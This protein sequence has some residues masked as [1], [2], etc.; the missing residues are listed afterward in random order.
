MKMITF[1]DVNET[2]RRTCRICDSD[3]PADLTIYPRRA[4]NV[5]TNLEFDWGDS[6]ISCYRREV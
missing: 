3:E 2:F 6:A 5:H 4:I 1:G